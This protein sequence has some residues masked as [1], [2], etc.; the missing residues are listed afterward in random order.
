MPEKIVEKKIGGSFVTGKELKSFVGKW[1][2]FFEGNEMPQSKDI[3]GAAA[4]VHYEMAK[5]NATQYYA[6][7]MKEFFTENLGLESDQLE[8]IHRLVLRVFLIFFSF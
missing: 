8:L 4:E 5:A 3:F 1:A 2:Q 6:R 7:K